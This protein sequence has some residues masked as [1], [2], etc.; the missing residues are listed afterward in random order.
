MP[1]GNVTTA[2]LEEPSDAEIYG[3]KD[4]IQDEEDTPVIGKEKP[5]P[6]VISDQS[7]RE[8]SLCKGMD[9]DFFHPEQHT[10]VNKQKEVCAKC[11]VEGQ[12]REYA[13]TMVIRSGI[14]GGTSENQ[15]EDMRRELKTT[16]K[17]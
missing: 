11:P 16:E 4:D 10:S 15:R 7:W 5:V 13:L 17:K 1:R 9:P 12:C 2:E 14:W 6:K 3:L 8:F